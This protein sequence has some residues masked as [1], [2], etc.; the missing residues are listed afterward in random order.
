MICLARVL[1]LN[2]VNV[3]CRLCSYV[4][5]FRLFIMSRLPAPS[6]RIIIC[7]FLNVLCVQVVGEEAGGVMFCARVRMRKVSL[8]L[9][10][11]LALRLDS[12]TSST[13]S[14]SRW[15]CSRS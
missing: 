14:P 5:V 11:S 13:A 8:N 7:S 4:I 12:S 3:L 15:D 9:F 10:V 2:V 1:K 6:F